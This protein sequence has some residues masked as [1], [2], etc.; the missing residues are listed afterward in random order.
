MLRE[1]LRVVVRA[2]V[3][4]SPTHQQI[5]SGEEI[6]GHVIEEHVTRLRTELK[7]LSGK[8]LRRLSFIGDERPDEVHI[9]VFEWVIARRTNVH[10]GVKSIPGAF[11]VGAPLSLGPLVGRHVRREP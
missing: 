4:A 10:D 7:L 6:A 9:D 8:E 3:A 1:S 2:K 5:Q 11:A